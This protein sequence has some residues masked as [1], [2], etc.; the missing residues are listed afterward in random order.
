MAINTFR[1]LNL[2]LYQR[3]SCLFF[4][5]ITIPCPAGIRV[6]TAGYLFPPHTLCEHKS[7][8]YM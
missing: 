6:N 7:K 8:I 2:I 4:Q 1:S 5:C 3:V